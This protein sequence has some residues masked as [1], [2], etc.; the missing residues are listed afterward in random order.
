MKTSSNKGVNVTVN[1]KNKDEQKKNRKPV[2]P[3]TATTPKNAKDETPQKNPEV[4]KT[5]D[6]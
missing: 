2:N 4:E 6:K 3:T 5:S 1:I